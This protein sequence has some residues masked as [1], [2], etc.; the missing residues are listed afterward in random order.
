M[1]PD[2]QS[3]PVIFFPDWAISLIVFGALTLTGLAAAALIW[4]ILKDRRN[5]E[6]W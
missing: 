2:P 3:W 5:K 4:L 6:I 1:N